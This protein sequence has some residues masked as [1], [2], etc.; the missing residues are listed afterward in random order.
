MAWT[1][2]AYLISLTQ[3]TNDPGD[4]VTQDDERVVYVNKKSIRQAEFY[5]A[6]AAGL[7]PE[8]MF[9]I[10]SIE[11]QGERKLSYEISP[12]VTRTYNIIRTYDRPD[13]I[14]E[15]VCSGLVE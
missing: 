2:I 15:L 9:E 4:V 14:T 1:D 3:T 11:Y 12:G 13:E 7:R 6:A 5:Q 8:I 10:R